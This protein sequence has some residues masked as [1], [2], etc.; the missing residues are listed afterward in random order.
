M[1]VAASQGG[2]LRRKQILELGMTVNEVRGRLSRGQ[3]KRLDGGAIQLYDASVPMER[4]RAAVA[5]LPSAVA[6]H[7]AAAEVHSVKGFAKGL[8]VVSV[9]S[10]TTHAF[11]GVTVRRNHDLADSHITT[12]DGLRVTTV[13]RTV[14]DM[15][16]FCSVSHLSDVLRSLILD[17]RVDLDLLVAIRDSVARRGRP[18]SKVLREV[19]SELVD[20]SPHVASKLE[21]LG[22]ALL[23][24][25]DCGRFL[26]EF[27]LPWDRTRRFDDAYPDERVAIEWDSRRWHTRNQEFDRDRARDNAVVIHGWKL[28]RFT[29]HDVANRPGHVVATVRAAFGSH[30]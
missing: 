14:V 30:S 17:K 8:A 16:R 13:E 24:E 28:L 2:C 7:E 21:A 15:A 20:G 22:R 12:R 26:S 18:G 19:T 5:V 9:H 25:A 11:P 29:W 1:E 3:W 23:L 6:S 10:R 4:V 27:P